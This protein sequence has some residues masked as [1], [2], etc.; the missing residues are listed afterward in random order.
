MRL[1]ESELPSL[2]TRLRAISNDKVVA[3]RRAVLW[4]RD[5]FVYKDMYN[6]DADHRAQLLGT[7][8]PQQDAFL[9]LALALEARARALGR[10]PEPP[11]TW[12]ARNLRLLGA[13]D[14]RAKL[15]FACAGAS[16]GCRRHGHAEQAT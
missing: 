3:M 1:L 4:L 14:E 15:I 7:G 10:L 12:R 11:T 6:P 5:Y 2:V 13:Q 8:R 9:L 16:S